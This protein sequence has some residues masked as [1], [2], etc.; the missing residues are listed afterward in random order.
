MAGE[1]IMIVEDNE[2]NLKLLRDLLAAYGY[3]TV[4]ARSGEEAV[5]LARAE[6][7]ELVLMD[8]QLPGMD[9][10]AALRE[11]R[12]FPESAATPIVA[13]TA[14]VMK[15]DRD[16]FLA[17]GFDAYLEKP[18]NVRELRSCLESFLGAGADG[19]RL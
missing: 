9:G 3:R 4:E 16:R 12:G 19:T 15:E 13:V 2:R 14:F 5:A 1:L 18:V 10:V 17:A 7:P 11:L 6:H 8:I